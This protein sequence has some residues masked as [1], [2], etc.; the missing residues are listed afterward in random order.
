MSTPDSRFEP[1]DGW[2]GISILLVLAAHLLPL[3]P[4]VLQFNA[5]AGVMG[6]ALFFTLSG[7]LITSFLLNN[8]TLGDFLMRRIARIVPLAWI[9]FLVALPMVNASGEAWLA[10]FFF[11]ANWPPMQ[12][13]TT[14]GHIWSLCVEMHFYFGIALIVACFGRRG[15]LLIPVLCIAFT[16]YRVGNHVHVAINTYYRVDEILAGAILALIHGNRLSLAAK[17]MIGKM[18]PYLLAVLFV[19]SCHPDGGFLNYFRPYLAALL[20]GW[21]LFNNSSRI[22]TSLNNPALIYIATISYALYVIHPIFG[23]T[24]LGSGEG[25]EKYLK[26]PLYIALVFLLAHLST[27]HYEQRF[28]RCAKRLSAR[29]HRKSVAVN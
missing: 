24:W 29:W 7:F 19:A 15:L 2:R 22:A 13:T 4:S 1:L 8:S 3:G 21:T 14:T 26:R 10:H 23:H 18:N 16:L 6:M 25:W 5:M 9:Y 28:T 17:R 20:V 27:F 11:Y 12:L